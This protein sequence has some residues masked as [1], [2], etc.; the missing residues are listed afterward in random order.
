MQEPFPVEELTIVRL[1]PGISVEKFDC[2]NDDLNDF[3]RS[4]AFVYAERKLAQ[5]F[6]AL[7]KNEPIA[8]ISVCTDA[9][10][11]GMKERK[12][13]FGKEKPHV[14]YPGIKV[15][16]LA[17]A[18][19]YKSRGVGAFLVKYIVGKAIAISEEVGCRFVTVD[20]YPAQL[21]FYAE[22]G[23][24]KNLS[25]SSGANVSMRLDIYQWNR[26]VEKAGSAQGN[27][28]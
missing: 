11:L 21:K 12:D 16:R 22:L 24:V 28:A 1:K 20:A 15:A 19:P 27:G 26:Q 6:I 17:T 7:Y 5:T 9:I 18:T 14:D 2:G 10:R 4:D 13:E 23:F 3:I 8:F 25:D